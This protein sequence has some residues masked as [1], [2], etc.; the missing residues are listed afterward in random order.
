MNMKYIGPELGARN[1]L[2]IRRY[3][4]APCNGKWADAKNFL[5]E[6][7]AEDGAPPFDKSAGGNR[8]TATW[9]G[10]LRGNVSAKVV[11]AAQPHAE[12]VRAR[13]YCDIRLADKIH[14]HSDLQDHAW[15][16]KKNIEG[17]VYCEP[18]R[19]RPSSYHINEAGL[20][21]RYGVPLSSLAR[22]REAVSFP[23][24]LTDFGGYD[25]PD[26]PW[27]HKSVLAAWERGR[28]RK[29]NRAIGAEIGVSR[30]TID[31]AGKTT[32]HDLAVDESR[33]GRD[34]KVFSPKPAPRPTT[35][36]L[37]TKQREV[38]LIQAAQAGDLAARDE[39]IVSVQPLIAFIAKRYA[40]SPSV[41]VEELVAEINVRG[42][43]MS[44]INAFD[45]DKGFR[46]ATFAKRQIEWAILA[47]LKKHN[48]RLRTVS[49][50]TPFGDS[51]PD[52][53]QPELGDCV[54]ADPGDE[55]ASDF[56]DEVRQ[57]LN[58]MLA[59][60]NDRERL[61]IESKHGL[62]GKSA[63]TFEQIGNTLRIS[64]QR[65]RQIEVAAFRKAGIPMA[66][67]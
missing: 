54:A 60:L 25:A 23:E 64:R 40:T 14:C 28:T 48:R 41:T 10:Q 31:R 29:S 19:W 44:A 26:R 55:P 46:F 17:V 50:N 67:P 59:V 56:Y 30:D 43:I 5:S 12:L 6:P 66:R 53:D 51:E 2:T 65:V 13:D 3:T 1:R 63:S 35:A 22:W 52:Q 18:R 49:L 33:V 47:Y 57:Q 4:P 27:W 38:E 39:I 24:S 20:A 62:N 16:I 7:P 37:L 45:A 34:G 21:T 9:A 58:G 61:I 32:G 11:K 42:A 15:R 36:K 8:C